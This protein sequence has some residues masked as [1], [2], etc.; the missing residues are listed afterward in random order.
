[1]SSIGIRGTLGY[2]SG[3]LM[4]GLRAGER[5]QAKEASALAEGIRGFPCRLPRLVRC[6]IEQRR[7]RMPSPPLLLSVADMRV[8]LRFAAAGPTGFERKSWRLPLLQTLAVVR[9]LQGR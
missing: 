7:R 6:R 5:G 2:L 9:T 8:P 3:S 4:P 1:M